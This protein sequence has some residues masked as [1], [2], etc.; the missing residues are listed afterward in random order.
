MIYLA[1]SFFDLV[2]KKK[3]EQ[4][5]LG[6]RGVGVEKTPVPIVLDNFKSARF[7]KHEVRVRAF[8]TP[9]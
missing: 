8:P 9:G 7:K 3:S 6:M 2:T 5:M 4:V 1:N